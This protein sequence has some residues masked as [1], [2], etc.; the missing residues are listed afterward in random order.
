MVVLSP[1]RMEQT[2]PL[3]HLDIF[4]LRAWVGRASSQRKKGSGTKVLLLK[5]GRALSDQSRMWGC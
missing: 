2:P 3:R 5:E 1:A 4:A